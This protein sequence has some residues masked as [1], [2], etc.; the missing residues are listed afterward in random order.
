MKIMLLPTF[1]FI[2]RFLMHVLPDR[3]HR[4]RHYGF[5]AGS[6]RK[7]KV[8]KIRV[9]LRDIKSVEPDQPLDETASPLTLREPC[10]C[11][12]GQ[13]RIVETFRGGQIPRTRAPARKQVA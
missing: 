2:R 7:E 3:F 13:M 8:A 4:I 5:L 9:L 10:P 6:G 1:E 12:R 11:C